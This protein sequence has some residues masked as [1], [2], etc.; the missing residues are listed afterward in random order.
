MEN[1]NTIQQEQKLH[2]E[3]VIQEITKDLSQLRKDIYHQQERQKV[4]SKSDT[5]SNPLPEA[6]KDFF[7]NFLSPF[8]DDFSRRLGSL[9]NLLEEAGFFTPE[10]KKNSA[11]L[12]DKFFNQVKISDYI[13]NWKIDIGKALFFAKTIANPEE[14]ATLQEAINIISQKRA[15]QLMETLKK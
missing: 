13:D 4:E 1:L 10:N 3:P 15:H 14:K 6:L 8:I 5:L 11:S 2:E 7:E 12:V 9:N